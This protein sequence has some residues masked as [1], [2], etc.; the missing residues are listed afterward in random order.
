MTQTCHDHM[1]LTKVKICVC[2]QKIIEFVFNSGIIVI[3]FN[4]ILDVYCQVIG[5]VRSTTGISQVEPTRLVNL[6]DL[7]DWRPFEVKDMGNELE[8][9]F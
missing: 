6:Y 2:Y 8:N 4:L 9:N 5:V 3:I 1:W 7:S